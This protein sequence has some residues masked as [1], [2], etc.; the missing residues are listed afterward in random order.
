MYKNLFKLPLELWV[1]SALAGGILLCFETASQ[2]GWLSN[3]TGINLSVN[4]T[5][6]EYGPPKPYPVS[7]EPMTISVPAANSSNPSGGNPGIESILAPQN[8]VIY[9]ST[10][11]GQDTNVLVNIGSALSCPSQ[12]A[13]RK[14]GHRL[15]D[16][17]LPPSPVDLYITE[18]A[19]DSSKN[20]PPT[21]VT[22]TYR[23]PTPPV[24]LTFQLTNNTNYALNYT[25]GGIYQGQNTGRYI[26]TVPLSAGQSTSVTVP[27]GPNLTQPY[28][29]G[30]TV[31]PINNGKY[32]DVYNSQPYIRYS[33]QLVPKT[34]TV[35]C[36]SGSQYSGS[37][38][39]NGYFACLASES[40]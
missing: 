24:T 1:T 30:E 37:P 33:T 38:Y 6:M 9:T 21:K 25:I 39:W 26:Q 40:Y 34:I 13:V 27:F 19:S 10:T 14:T 22:L 7:T 32:S 29:G 5:P 16:I 36:G 35:T 23:A 20:P 2:A 18:C 4:G 3:N 8:G 31:Q 15:S 11:A 17:P 12:Q 28:V